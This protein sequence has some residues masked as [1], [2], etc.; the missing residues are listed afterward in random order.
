M[1]VRPGGGQNGRVQETE[2]PTATKDDLDL[3]RTVF[4]IV[5]RQFYQDQ[6]AILIDVLSKHLV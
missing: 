4:Q 6:H 2:V 5:A 1:S 3:V